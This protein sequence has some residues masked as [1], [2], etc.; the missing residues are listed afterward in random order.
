MR[1]LFGRTTLLAVSL[2]AAGTVVS[3]GPPRDLGRETLPQGDGW[4]SEGAG[5]TGGSAAAASQVY[6]VTNRQELIA[7][8]NDGVYPP[9]SSTPSN[10]PKIIYVQ[11]TIDANVDDA[12]Q[13]L[14]Y[15][16]F[17]LPRLP[18]VGDQAG[19]QS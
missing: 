10:A 7:A 19:K 5:T 14:S 1:L 8:L 17:Q 9:P 6:V 13:P 2:L 16:A 15:S 3:A 18:S 11:G 12:N 4:A